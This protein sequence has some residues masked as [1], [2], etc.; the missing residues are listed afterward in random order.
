[1]ISR[2]S[3]SPYSGTT[4]PRSGVSSN[5]R[6]ALR[7]RLMKSLRRPSNRARCMNRCPP[8]HATH[9]PTRSV[10]E[11]FRHPTFDLFLTEGATLIKVLQ[12]TVD[13]LANVDV[14]LNL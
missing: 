8:G 13:L 11:P 14:V 4:R 5:D 12:A 10:V 9:L 6:A 1:M 3:R 2:T 7:I